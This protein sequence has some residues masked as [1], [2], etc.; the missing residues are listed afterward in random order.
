M[1]WRKHSK[2]RGGLSPGF[3]ATGSPVVSRRHIVRGPNVFII[4]KNADSSKKTIGLCFLLQYGLTHAH[5]RQ[6]VPAILTLLT[7]EGP[8]HA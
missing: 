4:T 2:A 6:W 3:G 5:S 7:R 8:D 1:M